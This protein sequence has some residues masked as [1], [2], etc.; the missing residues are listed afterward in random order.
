MTYHVQQNPNK[1]K[2]MVS[3]RNNGGQK[4][5]EWHTQKAAKRKNIYEL[6]IHN[7]QKELSKIK[8]K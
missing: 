7:Q 3:L 8:A 6:R 2:K 5:L 4:A 1:E